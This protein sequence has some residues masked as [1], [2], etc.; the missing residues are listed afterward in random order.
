MRA[1]DPVKKIHACSTNSFA[2]SKG[3]IPEAN[4]NFRG[5]RLFWIGGPSGMFVTI[6]VLH[7]L[8]W[9][10]VECAIHHERDVRRITPVYMWDEQA[11]T[12]WSRRV[13]SIDACCHSEKL[14]ALAARAFRSQQCHTRA[15]YIHWII[16]K[17]IILLYSEFPRYQAQ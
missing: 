3:F 17:H 1:E 9:R 14:C 4:F 6:D 12:E 8:G 15:S 10:C 2:K 13:I 7:P 11:L 16:H 5:T